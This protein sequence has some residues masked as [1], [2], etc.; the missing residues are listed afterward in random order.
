LFFTKKECYKYLKKQKYK[1]HIIIGV[2]KK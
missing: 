1:L 2:R